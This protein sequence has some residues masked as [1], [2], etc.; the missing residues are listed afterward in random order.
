[1]DQPMM[2]KGDS[3]LVQQ[4]VKAGIVPNHCRRIVLD[5]EIGEIVKLYYECYGDDKLLEIDIPG[6]LGA[7]V[8]IVNTNE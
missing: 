2:V 4:F 7:D 6:H 8:K 1:M 5:M 3:K